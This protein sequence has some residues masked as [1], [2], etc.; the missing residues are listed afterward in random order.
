M[1]LF[2]ISYETVRSCL[3]AEVKASSM[4]E[5]IVIFLQNHSDRFIKINNVM[6]LDQDTRNI[7]TI[8]FNIGKTK[9]E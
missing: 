3:S 8:Y 6:F 7:K 1:N 9:T 4:N 2:I 5:A